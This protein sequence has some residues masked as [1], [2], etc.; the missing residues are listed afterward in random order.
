MKKKKAKSIGQ[1]TASRRTWGFD[2]S[3][4]VK[5]NKKGKGSYSRKNAKTY[6]KIGA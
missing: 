4:R 3:T 1:M 5:Q 2:S 6:W